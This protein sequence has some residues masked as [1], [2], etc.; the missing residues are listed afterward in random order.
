[1]AL[2]LVAILAFFSVVSAFQPIVRL[3]RWVKVHHVLFAAK[4]TAIK[5]AQDVSAKFGADSPEA[6]VAW[7]AVEEMDAADNSAM[8]KPALADDDATVKLKME[9][10]RIL[11]AKAQEI[12]TQIEQ[13][14]VNLKETVSLNKESVSVGQINEGAY[15]IAKAEAEAATAK[16]G[17]D[18]PEARS[19][20]DTVNEI[21][22]ADDEKIFTGGL[23]EECLV[24]SME[25]CVE[26]NK[27][28]EELQAIIGKS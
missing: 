11:T 20:W 7:E 28:M 6:R 17:K 3:D 10:L 25:K 8:W 27:A 15:A 26:Y 1:M 13:N 12:T 16:F 14:I 5:E 24:S 19:A 9:E 18:S 22:S 2:R 21:E 23:D 4:E